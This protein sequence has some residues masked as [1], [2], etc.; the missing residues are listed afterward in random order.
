MEERLKDG[1]RPQRIPKERQEIPDT[2]LTWL[3]HGQR[4]L[5][6][7]AIFSKMTGMALSRLWQN[8]H[9][10]DP[11]DFKRCMDLLDAVPEFSSRMQEMKVVSMQWAVVVNHWDELANQYYGECDTGTCHKLD[12]RMKELGC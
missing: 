8:Q 9:P 3:K 11:L 6:S 4:G 1:I 7:E 12:D 2:A 5:S 10:C